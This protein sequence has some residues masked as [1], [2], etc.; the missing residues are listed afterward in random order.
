M[1]DNEDKRYHILPH[2]VLTRNLKILCNTCVRMVKLKLINN[3]NEIKSK[4]R[5][6][7]HKR[8]KTNHVHKIVLTENAK[9]L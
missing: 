7:I 2:H 6:S 8:M 9:E 3:A 5:I 1:C 4:G